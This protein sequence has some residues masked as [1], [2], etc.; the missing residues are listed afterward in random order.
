MMVYKN[1]WFLQLLRTDLTL[2][3]SLHKA[4]DRLKAESYGRW[5]ERLLLVRLLGVAMCTM[6]CYSIVE[7]DTVESSPPISWSTFGDLTAIRG[8]DDLTCCSLQ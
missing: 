1:S 8:L 5:A 6:S 2:P 7:E 3:P 4:H